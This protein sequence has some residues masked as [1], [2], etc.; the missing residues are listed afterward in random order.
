MRHRDDVASKPVYRANPWRIRRDMTFRT[1]RRIAMALFLAAL[2]C[3]IGFFLMILHPSVQRFGLSRVSQAIGYDLNAGNMRLSMGIKPGIHVQDFQVSSKQG[4]VLLSASDLTLIPN[5][6]DLFLSDTG[7]FFS[8]SAEA[9]NLKFQLTASGKTRDYALPQVKFQGKYDLNKWLLQIVSLKTITPETS[10]SATGHVQ[11]SPTAS[12]CLDLSFTSPF[13]TVDTFKALLPGL[14]LPEWIN[15]ELLPAFKQGDIRMDTLSLRGSLKQIETLNQPEHAKVLGLNLT[16]RN[17]VMQHSDKNAPELRDVSCAL[18]IEDGVFSLDGLSGRFWQSAFQNASVVI[19]D[20]YA[21]RL[22]YLVQTEASLILSDVNHLKNLPLFPADVQQKI[23][24]LQT[25]DGTADIRV[26]V[27]Y[28]TG[29]PFPKIITSAISLQSVKVTHPLLRLPLMLGNAAIDSE[30]DQPV[31]FSGR[32]L[33]G[34]TEFQVQGSADNSWGHLSA[35]ATTRADV[36]ELIELAFPQ[37]AIGSWIYGP[38]DAEGLLSDSFAILDPARINMGKGY[39]RFKGRQAIVEYHR[40]APGMHWI[41][42]I[43]IVQEPAQNLIQLIRPGA[44]VLDGSVSLEGVLTLKA[45]DG[46]GDFSGLN[47]HARLLVEKGWIHQTSPILNALSLISLERIF[48][49]G[50]P[51]VQDGRLYFDRIEGDIE[52]EKGKILVQ[53]LTLQSPAI[54]AAGAGT[55]DLNRDH[56]Q[57]RIGLQPLGTMDSLVSSIPLIGNILTGKEK[58][59]IVYSLDVTG[60]LSNP[61]IKGVP[62]KNLGESA[63]GYLERLVFTPERILKSLMSLKNPRPQAPDYHAEF[64]RMTLDP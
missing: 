39:L 64:D 62:L 30:S 44:G 41:S 47:G 36:R 1:I 33:W 57:L 24:A 48:Q 58:S 29:R 12:P 5:L 13:M 17:L 6:F 63:L 40:P 9:G 3:G 49:P 4:K 42:H 15:R 55:I 8:G 52:I 45:S 19:P 59:L 46:T 51:G 26:S 27:A 25:I 32:G 34:K 54:N 38:L 28:E 23:Q 53:N 61:Q 22:R 35:R 50:S 56:L 43:H 16:L 14:L 31:Q 18:S 21:D 60:S 37:A 10:L 7:T 11:F 20:I 2:C